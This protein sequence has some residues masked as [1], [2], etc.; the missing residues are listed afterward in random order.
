MLLNNLSGKE[1]KIAQ[2]VSVSC[3]AAYDDIVHGADMH[4]EHMQAFV[5]DTLDICTLAQESDG[6]DEVFDVLGR[7]SFLRCSVLRAELVE[8]D[9]SDCLGIVLVSD[10]EDGDNDRETLEIA[11]GR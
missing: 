7:G 2:E 11:G 4:K 1:R 9:F 10:E 3:T 6:S 8:T 5:C